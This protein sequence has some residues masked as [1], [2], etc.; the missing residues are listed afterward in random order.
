[1]EILET[2]LLDRLTTIYKGVGLPLPLDA[3]SLLAHNPKGQH[4]KD[5]SVDALK[6]MVWHQ[7]LSWGSVENVA[8]YHTGPDCH[9]AP[10]GTE[11]IAYT[12]A[13]RRNGQVLLCN[14]LKKATWSHGFKDRAG[15]ENAEF[16][17]AM[18]EGYFLGE[19]VADPKAGNPNEAQI[20]SGLLL[21][22]VCKQ[23]WKW[24][25]SALCGHFD[26][27]KPACPGTLLQ[28]IIKAIRS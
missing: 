28:S 25:S 18:F 17:A 26:F 11:S 13:I 19:G 5:R 12:W 3:R 9:L 4:W 27:G 10:G 7:S 23:E 16:M 1:M 14:D 24:P 8:K 6:G 20:L 21:W 2:K 15:D 22:T